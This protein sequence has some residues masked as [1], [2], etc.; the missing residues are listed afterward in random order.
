MI[1]FPNINPVIFSVGPLAISWYSLAYVVGILCGW[2]YVNKLIL[3]HPL[4]INKKHTE[5][6]VSWAIISIIIGGRLGY[7]L[8]YDPEKYLANPIE[9][10]KTYE[11]GMSFHGGIF[12]VGLASYLY[13]RKN[14]IRFLSFSDILAVVA[15]IGLFLGRLANFINAELYGRP[16][17]VPW[18][19]IFPYSD[20]LPRHPS[21]LYE[22]LLEGFVLFWIMIY[23]TYRRKALINPGRISGIFLIFYGIFRAFIEFF[24]EPDVKIGFI[25]KYFTL[26]QLLC[27]PMIIIGIYLLT[28]STKHIIQDGDRLQNKINN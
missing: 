17:D 21:Q 15:P 20:G 25:A 28:Y 26:G 11:G 10:F 19:V 4:G 27:M 5:D 12:G 14:Q 24:R 2:Y 8:F 18:A 3:L 16:T 22:A 6:F 9:I 7:V 13:C 23:F 1:D